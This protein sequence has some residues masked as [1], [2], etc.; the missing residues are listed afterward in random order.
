MDIGEL[1]NNIPL[2]LPDDSYWTRCRRKNN[3][4]AR[5]KP[6]VYE[7]LALA[8]YYQINIT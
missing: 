1:L 8:Y 4:K 7:S 3:K 2:Y 5:A 6:S